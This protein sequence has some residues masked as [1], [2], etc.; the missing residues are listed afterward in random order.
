MS[1]PRYFIRCTAGGFVIGSRV[2]DDFG[3][4]LTKQ[5]ANRLC[6]LDNEAEERRRVALGHKTRLEFFVQE[7]AP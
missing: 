2:E 5:S 4:P 3:K 1:A 6:R 7:V